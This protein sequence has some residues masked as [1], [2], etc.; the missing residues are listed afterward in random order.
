MKWDD[1][2]RRVTALLEKMAND[3]ATPL[4]IRQ[5]AG[6]TMQA[7]ALVSIMCNQNRL[8]TASYAECLTKTEQLEKAYAEVCEQAAADD[9][10]E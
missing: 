4:L 6:I 1:L 5:I 10:T 7:L 8:Q 9:V 3:P 2:R